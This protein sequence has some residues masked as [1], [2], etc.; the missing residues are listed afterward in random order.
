MFAARRALH[1]K[2]HR[3]RYTGFYIAAVLFLLLPHHFF[4]YCRIILLLLP[5]HFFFSSTLKAQKFSCYPTVTNPTPKGD[6]DINRR[7][8]ILT[9][10]VICSQKDHQKESDIGPRAL[11]PKTTFHHAVHVLSQFSAFFFAVQ[12]AMS[13]R[14]TWMQLMGSLSALVPVVVRL[15]HSPPPLGAASAARVYRVLAAVVSSLRERI[16]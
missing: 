11:P 16:R 3:S 7:L 6:N 10:R 2:S 15:T 13:T 8:Y 12:T 5:H 9:I 1:A 4:C 14:G